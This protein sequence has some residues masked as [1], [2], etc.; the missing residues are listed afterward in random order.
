[1]RL[2]ELLSEAWA[3]ARSSTVASVLIALVVASMAFAA[4]VTVGQSAA[5]AAGVAR[6]MTSAGARQLSVI[7][8]RRE[9]FV[10]QRTLT[11]AAGLSTVQ[12]AAAF[13]MPRDVM[14]GV[15]GRGGQPVALW[16]VL[17]DISGLGTLE[18]GRQPLPGEAVVTPKA[19]RT[20]GFSG[21][22]GFVAS[23]DGLVS[24][25]VVGLLV[26]SEG[27]ADLDG[28]VL[29]SQP[30]ADGRELRVRLESVESAGSTVGIVLD[31]LRPL[32]PQGVQVSS[33][34]GLAET[35]KRL[36]AELRGYGRGLLL[37]ILS[38]GGFFVAAVVFADV[39][40]RRRDLGR[41]RTLGVTRSDLTTLV[42]L[43]VLAMAGAG[44]V[45]GCVAGWVTNQV[46][47]SATPIG[48]V[49]AIGVLGVLVAAVAAVPP[50]V[51]AVTRDPVRVMRTP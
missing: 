19:M 5:A 8:G 12:A 4:I 27:Y 15:I 51:V 10:N 1:M 35:A 46:Q 45:L 28:S 44:A 22:A 6:Q 21:P 16:P 50:A 24:V 47:S 9:G 43:R 42:V 11:A 49:V 40:I 25:P 48:F 36:D 7:D 3:S 14:N 41:R 2:R 31:V 20:L 38:V 23:A 13:G 33:P 34:G 29:V 30:D 32:D 17:S 18:Q 37:M 39:L 26:P